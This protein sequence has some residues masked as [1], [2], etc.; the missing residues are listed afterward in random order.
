MGLEIGVIAAIAGAA[1]TVGGVVIQYNAGQDAKDAQRRRAASEK[2]TNAA[3]A[4][5]ERRQQIREER[6]RRAR[7]LQSAENSGTAGSSGEFGAIGALSTNLNSNIGANLGSLRESNIMSGINQD[8]ANSQHKA[9]NGVLLGQV[10]S[11]IFNIGTSSLFSSTPAQPKAQGQGGG[12][13]P[14]AGE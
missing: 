1:A 10:G 7:V 4:A 6:I 3:A 14:I 13:I 12:Y 2:A 5:R 8:L 11:S 9:N